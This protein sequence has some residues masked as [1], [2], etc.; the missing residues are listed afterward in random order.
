MQIESE[1]AGREANCPQCNAEVNIPPMAIGPSVVIG[2][3]RLEKKLG[4]GSMGDVYLAEQITMKRKTAVK[5]LPP[6]LTRDPQS[7]ERFMHEVRTLA[8][9]EHPNIVSAFDAG[10]DDGTYYLAMSFVN[11]EDL[12]RIVKRDGFIPEDKSLKYIKKAAKALQ[13]AW[14]EHQLLHRDIKPENIMIDIHGEIKLMDLGI[15]KSVHEDSS[16]TMPGV[17]FGTPHYMSPEQAWSEGPLDFR[18]DLYSLGASLYRMVTGKPP[19]VGQSQ[20]VFAKLAR[21]E[22]F[23]MPKTIRSEISDACEHLIDVMMAPKPEQRYDNWEACIKDLDRV[24]KGQYPTLPRPKREGVEEAP[25]PPPPPS[26]FGTNTGNQ[27]IQPKDDKD[28]PRLT[29]ARTGANAKPEENNLPSTGTSGPVTGKLLLKKSTSTNMQPLTDDA[30]PSTATGAQGSATPSASTLTSAT[31]SAATPTGTTT[32]TGGTPTGSET[33]SGSTT[34]T[35]GTPTGTMT[36]GTRRRKQKES[37]V[38]RTIKTVATSAAVLCAFVVIYAIMN[39]GMWTGCSS[40]N[41]EDDKTEI[42]KVPD[43]KPETPQ[44]PPA[45]P[46]KPPANNNPSPK[47]PSVADLNRQVNDRFNREKGSLKVDEKSIA[48]R[49]RLVYPVPRPTASVDQVEKQVAATAEE[50]AKESFNYDER[51][52][53]IEERIEKEYGAYKV[54][55]TVRLGA[56][57]RGK[58]GTFEGVL[59]ESTETKIK[60]NDTW[61]EFRYIDRADQTRLD[62]KLAIRNVNAKTNQ[63]L[64]LLKEELSA[65]AKK[66]QGQFMEKALQDA[67]YVKKDGKWVPV[68][69]VFKAEV[70]SERKKLEQSLKNTI[71]REVFSKNG[72]VRKDGKWV[73]KET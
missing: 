3:F 60:I 73:P 29:L 28:R 51:V 38:K 23:P 53:E 41:G 49:L 27:V 21:P 8:R 59:Q 9:F 61:I 10:E 15:S 58:K 67:H 54:G 14:E 19:Y 69:D 1:F 65:H 22:P 32:P 34:P 36:A 55:D 56:Y 40:A 57:Y 70:A 24:I 12:D 25:P 72:Y 2:G 4:S 37:F 43:K 66:T 20:I 33:P 46:P 31:P 16:L 6:T 35:G 62:P 39:P 64:L 5:I 68:Q 63:A 11:G 50:K 71:E 44:K 7:V 26:A 42:V 13:F 30:T 45:Q 47:G 17:V 52:K 18:A 48:S